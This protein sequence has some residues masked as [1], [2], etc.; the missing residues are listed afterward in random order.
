MG[1]KQGGDTLSELLEFSAV[2]IPANPETGTHLKGLLEGYRNMRMGSIRKK[3]RRKFLMRKD[4]REKL[5][6]KSFLIGL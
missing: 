6:L 1:F 5:T 3:S 4:N 2:P